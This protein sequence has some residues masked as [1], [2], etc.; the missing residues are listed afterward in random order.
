MH[1]YISP[2]MGPHASKIRYTPLT[3]N[4]CYTRQEFLT[5]AN[6][7]RYMSNPPCGRNSSQVPPLTVTRG[8]A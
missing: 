3:Y 6:K 8:R 7:I 5:L 1:P 4:G 2:Q